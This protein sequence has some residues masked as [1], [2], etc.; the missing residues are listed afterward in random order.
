MPTRQPLADA[1][2]VVVGMAV[3]MQ[4]EALG[5][6]LRSAGMMLSLHPANGS[7]ASGVL[8]RA[9]MIYSCVCQKSALASCCVPM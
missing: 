4:G 7:G 9:V 6:V 2:G 5:A 1:L 3:H 8:N